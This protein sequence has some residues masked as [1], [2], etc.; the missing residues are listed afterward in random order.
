MDELNAATPLVTLLAASML[1]ATSPV[2]NCV[3][4]RVFAIHAI[5]DTRQCGNGYHEQH[6][7]ALA[8][9]QA[10]GDWP[11]WRLKA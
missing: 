1:H 6:H 5:H 8:R 9:R 7:I 10:A 11:T 4:V 3:P 2:A